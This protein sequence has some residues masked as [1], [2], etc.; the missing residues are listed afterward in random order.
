MISDF[1]NFTQASSPCPQQPGG[2]FFFFFRYTFSNGV[3]NAKNAASSD[4]R[5]SYVVVFYG[6]ES[7]VLE[8]SIIGLGYCRYVLSNGTT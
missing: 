2:C 7:A 1:A 8:V 3:L 4:F 6:R 5:I